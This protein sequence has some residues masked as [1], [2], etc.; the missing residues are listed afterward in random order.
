MINYAHDTTHEKIIRGLAMGIALSMCC[1]E[2][3][4]DGV[5]E[6]LSRDRDP[7]LRYGAMYA[8]GLAYCGTG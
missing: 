3:A 5:I 8:V 4:A 1:Q 7:L 6:Q 2:E